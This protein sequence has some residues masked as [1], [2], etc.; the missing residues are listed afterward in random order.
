MTRAW[1]PFDHPDRSAEKAGERIRL[2]EIRAS[3]VEALRREFGDDFFGGFERTEYASKNYREFLLPDDACSR[4]EN[5]AKLLGAYPICVTT[6][7]LHGSIGWKLGE[8][9]AFSKAI[10]SERISHELPGEFAEGRNFLGFDNTDECVTATRQLFADAGLRSRMMLQNRF[11]Y[12]N[13]V[14]PAAAI[15]A[16]LDLAIPGWQARRPSFGS[17]LP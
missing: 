9:L 12:S 5:Y 14:E 2:N 13:H 7:G 17:E 3:C 4:K 16:S 15:R 11:Y 6:R 8:Y 10:V 1:D